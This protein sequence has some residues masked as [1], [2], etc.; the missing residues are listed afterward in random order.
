MNE[1][2]GAYG[3]VHAPVHLP[4]STERSGCCILKIGYLMLGALPNMFKI[5]VNGYQFFC[6]GFNYE[7]TDG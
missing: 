4:A 5:P 1:K 6:G 3:K 2:E 7:T